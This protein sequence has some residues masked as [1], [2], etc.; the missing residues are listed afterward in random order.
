MNWFKSFL[1][2]SIGKKLLMSLTGLFLCT[3]LIAHLSGNLQLFKNDSGLSFNTYAVFMTTNPFIKFVSYGLYAIIVFHALWG[4]YLVFENKKARPVGYQMIDGK[5]NSTWS[6][7]NMGILGSIIL[8]FIVL[9]MSGFWAQYKFGTTPYVQYD[10]D[11]SSG[12]IFVSEYA[13]QL[14]TKMLVNKT[15]TTET[16]VVKDLYSVVQD[17][18]KQWWIVLIYIVSMIALSFHLIHGFKSA[19][20]TVGFN[21]K[22][23]NGLIHS[24]G[25]FIFGIIIPLLFAAM[26]IFF[27]IQ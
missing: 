2:S 3:F 18:F 11:L 24:I 21:H 16:I 17:A 23:Y 27:F 26:P 13:G 1:K 4:L 14:D 8:V 25:V 5:A 9:H 15:N 12:E 10:R 19:F 22:K 7:R 20:Q 6:S